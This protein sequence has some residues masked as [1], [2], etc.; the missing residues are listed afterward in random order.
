M[1][2]PVK[3]LLK[4]DIDNP[5]VPLGNV[6]FGLTYRLMRVAARPEPITA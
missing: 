3:T 2:D 5:F 6:L 4:V 1:I